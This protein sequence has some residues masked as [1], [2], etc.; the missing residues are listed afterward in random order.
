[1]RR[2]LVTGGGGFVGLA[3]V[4][5]LVD[6]GVDTAV[7]GRHRYPEAERAGARCFVGDIR[8]RDF[9]NR[10]VRDNDTVFHVAAKAG[11]W[12]SRE[13]YYSINVTGTETTASDL[14]TWRYADHPS[15]A[16]ERKA[17]ESEDR[18]GR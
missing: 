11:I 15:S 5:R 7:A 13:S 1:M 18:W 2:A 12:G 17:G 10:A 16:Q 4:K 9:V 6:M 14:G 3:L 8:D